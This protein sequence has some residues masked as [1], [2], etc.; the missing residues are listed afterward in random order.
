M[1]PKKTDI[2]LLGPAPPYRGGI[3]ETQMYFGQTLVEEKRAIQLWTFNHLYP[4]FLFPGQSQLDQNQTTTSDI[5]QQKIHA[6][7]PLQWREVARELS[8]IEPSVAVFRLWTP[9]LIPC[10]NALAK[11]LPS[12]TKKIALVDNWT[13]HEPKPWDRFLLKRFVHQM[14]AFCCFSDAVKQEILSIAKNKPVWSHPHPLPKSMP[15]ALPKNEA[16][17]R[18]KAKSNKKNL[19]FF[20]LIRAYKGLDLLIKA[21]ADHRDKTLWIVG[22]PY[23]NF[24]KYSS[25]IERLKLQDNVALDLQFVT[26]EKARIYFSAADAVVLPYK[27]A[28]QSGV[29]ATAYHFETPLLVTHH[30]GMASSVEKDRTGIIVSPDVD[31]ISKGIR[32]IC[33]PRIQQLCIQQYQTTREKYTWKGFVHDWIKFIE[34]V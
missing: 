15:K 27:T 7:N 22:E 25:I 11:C 9:F 14:D 2:V 8:N 23:E 26:H 24:D 32:E 34:H 17:Q 20:G 19:L 10:W 29:L 1:R 18:I 6:Y 12:G 13:P 30:P 28:T 31:S 16:L 5:I 21:M 33:S 4:N 3:A